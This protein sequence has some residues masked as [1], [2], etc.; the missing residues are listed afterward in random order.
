VVDLTYPKKGA[1]ELVVEAERG[2][3]DKEDLIP[4]PRLAP[5][6]VERETGV[7]AIQAKGS[8][9]VAVPESQGVQALDPQELPPA[10][11]GQAEHPLLYAYRHTGRPVLSLAVTRHPDVAVLTTTVDLANALTMMTKRGETVTRVQYH[12][13]NRVK[14][15]LSVRLPEGAELWSTFVAGEPVKPVRLPEGGYRLPLRRSG[16]GGDADSILVE[17]VYFARRAPAGLAGR[18]GFDLPLPDAPVSR[19]LWSLY[20]PPASRALAFGGDMDRRTDFAPVPL[21]TAQ[22]RDERRRDGMFARIA[23]LAKK[24]LAAQAPAPAAANDAAFQ[25]QERLLAESLN[26]KEDGATRAGVFPVY[27]QI[28]EEGALFHFERSM[29]VGGSPRVT[30][31]YAAEGLFKAGW[32]LFAVALAGAAFRGRRRFTPLLERAK[33]FLAKRTSS[34]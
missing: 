6:D 8:V 26:A 14:Q 19:A 23:G 33:A 5:L 4:L 25:S 17:I 30:V 28:P 27:F 9:E 32:V 1:I 29:I 22:P 18:A 10:L 21:S 34:F 11:W 20:L 3:A 15:N 12:V 16:N 7:L 13:R 2:L 31:T 24:A